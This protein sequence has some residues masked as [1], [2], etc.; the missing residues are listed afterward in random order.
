MK[1]AAPLRVV[2]R[3][4]LPSEPRHAF[5]AG[6]L[7]AHLVVASSLMLLPSL[8][9]RPALGGDSLVVELAGPIAGAQAGRPP[10]AQ[11]PPKPAPPEKASVVKEDTREV[12]APRPK[13]P[14]RQEKR[15]AEG[16]EAA[17]R[18]EAASLPAQPATGEGAAGTAGGVES[19]TLGGLELGWYG[20]A[21]TAALARGWL[22]PV[23]EGVGR[24]LVAVVAFDIRRD[25][26]IENARVV[27]SS[28]VPS[29]DRSALRAVLEASP[30][31]PVP[32]AWNQQLLPAQFRFVWRPEEP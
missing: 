28:G 5:L 17:G 27:E 30:L 6:S 3:V 2:L 26:S 21:V 1:G 24:D 7:A 12:A 31:P 25:G 8:G 4:P 11:P 20:A 22:R 13:A 16:D 15:P 14:A 32:A 9:R 19:M 10:A 18:Q 29:L 23:L